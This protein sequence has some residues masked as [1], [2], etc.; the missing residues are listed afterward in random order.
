[1]R[2]QN[3]ACPT[4]HLPASVVSA[5]ACLD[6]FDRNGE[7]HGNK[8][9]ALHPGLKRWQAFYQPNRFLVKEGCT[10]R[11]ALALANLSFFADNAYTNTVPSMPELRASSGYLVLE[12]TYLMISCWV[13]ACLSFPTRVTQEPNAGICST[14]MKGRSEWTVP[15]RKSGSAYLALSILMAG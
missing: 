15:E 3:T 13:H 8:F 11:S 4:R 2:R 1:M 5:V 6:E 9:P 14:T 7:L 12:L 10:S